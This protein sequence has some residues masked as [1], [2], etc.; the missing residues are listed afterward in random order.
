MRRFRSNLAFVLM[1]LMVAQVMVAPSLAK[2]EDGATP[3]ATPAPCAVTPIHTEP[4]TGSGHGSGLSGV[5]W[6]VVPTGDVEMTAHFYVQDRSAPTDRWFPLGESVKILWTF[7]E[8]VRDLTV[9]VT[10]PAAPGAD[11]PDVL[12]TGPANTL[13]ESTEWPSAFTAP[14]AGCLTLTLHATTRDGETL[15]GTM[16][17]MAAATG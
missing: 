17:L 11:Y 3:P 5:P 14:A 13:P 9:T 10:N 16:T 15:S 4:W 8:P 1:T 2:V 12:T 7:T 6:A